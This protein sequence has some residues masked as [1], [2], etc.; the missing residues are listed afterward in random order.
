[1]RKLLLLASL[2]AC[3]GQSADTKPKQASNTEATDT[4]GD[5]TD[6]DAGAATAD[7]NAP[8]KDPCSVFEGDLGTVLMQAACEV[9][10]PK[11][12]EKAVEMKGKLA[13]TLQPS[14]QFISPGS[15]DDLVLTL[16]NKSNAPLPLFFTLDPTPRFPTETYDKKD[17]RVDM[18]SAKQPALPSGMPPREATS[19]ETARIVLVPNG[20]VKLT[21]PWSAVKMRW[22]PEKL[23]GTPPEEGYPRVPAGNLPRGTYTI[24]VAMPMTLVFEGMDRE[25]SAPKTQVVVK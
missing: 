2:I 3:G 19:H 22:A 20:T 5:S 8:K 21:V 12:E 25:V 18:P 7:P 23:R 17:R 9:P 15:S 13:V 16:T 1:M 14:A 10:N 6:A 24:R 11:P 4:T